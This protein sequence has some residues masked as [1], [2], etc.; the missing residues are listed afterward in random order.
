MDVWITRS[1]DG[2]DT[3]ALSLE[4]GR[5]H[6]ASA[7]LAGMR[8]LAVAIG[9]LLTLSPTITSAQDADP[10]DTE[11]IEL[12]EYVGSW[13]GEEEDWVLFLGDANDPDSPTDVDL[14]QLTSEAEAGGLES[15][16]LLPT[17]QP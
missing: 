11:F 7:G 9:A 1:S 14:D 15:T 12:L 3:G 13:D 17:A 16:S 10:A 8:Y 4:I 6:A 5:R 2:T